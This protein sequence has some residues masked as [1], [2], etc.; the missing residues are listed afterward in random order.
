MGHEALPYQ[1][2]VFPI[3]MNGIE[4]DYLLGMNATKCATLGRAYTA[5]QPELD[6]KVRAL[7]AEATVPQSVKDQYLTTSKWHDFCQYVFWADR[8]AVELKEGIPEAFDTCRELTAARAS[9]YAKVDTEQSGVSTNDVRQNLQM[10]LVKWAQASGL[11]M[12]LEDV[13]PKETKVS[14]EGTAGTENPQYIMFWM[15]VEQLE[16]LAASLSETAEEL[17]PL[18]PSSTILLEVTKESSSSW[19]GATE[20]KVTLK[21]NDEETPTALCGGKA[22]CSLASFAAALKNTVQ[23]N[24]VANFCA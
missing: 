5:M 24:D 1:T 4:Y 3:Q 10:R 2:T 22:S 13:T 6:E 15:Q 17:F 9:L 19:T 21:I 12:D 11:N 18:V 8:E 23:L 7:V 20:L 14:L 16:L